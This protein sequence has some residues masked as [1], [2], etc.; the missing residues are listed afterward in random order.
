MS[1]RALHDSQSHR[2]RLSK[3]SCRLF[4]LELF[5][6]ACD[7]VLGFYESMGTSLNSR[8]KRVR[9]GKEGASSAEGW[10]LVGTIL[11][12]GPQCT[13]LRFDAA[14]V[15]E[16]LGMRVAINGSFRNTG[17]LIS[18]SFI[19]G[20]PQISHSWKLRKRLMLVKGS[21]SKGVLIFRSRDSRAVVR[22]KPQGSV[23]VYL[24]RNLK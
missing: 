18:V 24:L 8:A 11:A 9:T 4:Y 15:R 23:I 20:N 3:G 21:G 1:C 7:V 6:P 19:F 2:S 17:Y 12:R 13:Q 22:N 5:K 10:K 16:G 14:F